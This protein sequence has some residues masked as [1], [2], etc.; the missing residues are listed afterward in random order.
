MQWKTRPLGYFSYT[1]LCCL[2]KRGDGRAAREG[3]EHH[4]FQFTPLREGRPPPI[5]TFMRDS[6]LFQFT[7][8]REGRPMPQAN[9]GIKL[10]ISIHAPARGATAAA[11][12]CCCQPLI[13]IHAPARGATPPRQ[14][15][16]ASAHISIHAPARGAT[17]SI[18]SS[19]ASTSDFNS[20]PCERG[21]RRCVLFLRT[22]Q[23]I[24][25]HAPAR[26][27]TWTTRG[28]NCARWYFNSRP[29]ERGDVD[30]YFFFVPNRLF[31]FTPLREGRLM[32]LGHGPKSAMLFQFTP[33]REGRPGV[34]RGAAAP[35]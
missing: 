3:G 35:R 27:A 17:P 11:A 15:P 33:L 32:P 10:A 9:M 24:S 1:V 31:Q 2:C 19:T 18:S 22:E 28:S 13:S 14:Q 23:T 6:F 5:H 16:G 30:V 8:L 20:R 34:P 4:L 21:D 12:A 29:C 26:G 7:P 25:I